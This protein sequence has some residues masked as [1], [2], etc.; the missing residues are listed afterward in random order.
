MKENETVV[1]NHPVVRVDHAVNGI[2]CEIGNRQSAVWE[3]EKRMAT[4]QGEI[5]GLREALHQIDR[6]AK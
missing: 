3:L 4:L 6:L 5:S 2:R 1:P